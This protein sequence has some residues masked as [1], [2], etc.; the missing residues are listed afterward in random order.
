MRRTSSTTCRSSTRLIVGDAFVKN[1]K[2]LIRFQDVNL[3]NYHSVWS[4]ENNPTSRHFRRWRA[5]CST[6]TTRRP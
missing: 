5:C 1:D 4:C 2:G 6:A 3:Y